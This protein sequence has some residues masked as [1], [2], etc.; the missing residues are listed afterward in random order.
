MTIAGIHI[1]QSLAISHCT[2]SLAI[3]QSYQGNVTVVEVNCTGDEATL[4]NCSVIYPSSNCSSYVGAGVSCYSSKSCVKCIHESKSH[5]L[6]I[7]PK[8]A[9]KLGDHSH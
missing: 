4:S 6:S 9:N 1:R 8:Q 3:G 2:G 7:S 5:L